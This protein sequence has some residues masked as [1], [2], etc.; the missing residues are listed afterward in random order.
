[1]KKSDDNVTNEI[2]ISLLWLWNGELYSDDITR[3]TSESTKINARLKVSGIL[4]NVSEYIY[5][6]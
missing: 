5:I 6:L 4:K 3:N 2:V 1:M